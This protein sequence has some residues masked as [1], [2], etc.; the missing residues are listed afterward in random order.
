MHKVPNTKATVKLY[1]TILRLADDV[2]FAAAL[3]KFQM[4]KAK[5]IEHEFHIISIFLFPFR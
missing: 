2:K 3:L 1:P 5:T 4:A